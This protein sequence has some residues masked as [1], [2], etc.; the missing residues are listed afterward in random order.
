MNSSTPA[1]IYS[2]ELR[3]IDSL[4]LRKVE[5]LEVQLIARFSPPLHPKEVQRSLIDCAA[6]YGS[7]PVR[8]YVPLLIERDVTRRL[9]GLSRIRRT[10][11][12]PGASVC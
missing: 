10:W 9:R 6:S 12:P 8:L 11:P 2:P 4:E 1:D 3:K 7:A 5:N